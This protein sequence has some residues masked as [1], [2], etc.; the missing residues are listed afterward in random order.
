[1]SVPCQWDLMGTDYLERKS[2]TTHNNY[3][4]SHSYA[5]GLVNSEGGCIYFHPNDP[6]PFL[7]IENTLFFR[8]LAISSH[9]GAIH[10]LSGQFSMKKSTALKCRTADNCHGQFIRIFVTGL[11][12]H[13]FN[14]I[15]G[16]C[17]QERAL[18]TIIVDY[19]AVLAIENNSTRNKCAQCFG[20]HFNT[21][22]ANSKDT[23]KYNI[24]DSNSG[25]RYCYDFMYHN[26][27][28]DHILLKNNS[29]K[30]GL[31][32]CR[33]G[34]DLTMNNSI[35]V[36]NTVE[37]NILFTI[38]EGGGTINVYR[39]SIDKNYNTNY[40]AL[41]EMD[42]FPLEIKIN[43]ANN[44]CRVNEYCAPSK[45]CMPSNIDLYLMIFI[46]FFDS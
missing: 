19:S 34:G 5:I 2:V 31:I 10:Q 22:P 43:Y 35:I 13:F 36:D 1:M 42:Q 20:M 21:Q 24:I 32:N 37:D 30:S 38:S 9:G 45:E 25:D 44:I 23:Q 14:N 16:E 29:V 4:I 41:H 39:T 12:N 15:I 17:V 18:F 11:K 26:H 3:S 33:Y 40:A 28:V 27:N 6:N 46:L 7:Q 8:C